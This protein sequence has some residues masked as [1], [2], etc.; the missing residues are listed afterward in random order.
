MR[1]IVLF[2]IVLSS[3]VVFA[4]HNRRD[5][6][7]IG[8]SGGATYTTLLGSNFNVKPETGWIAGLSVRGNYYNDWSAVFGMQFTESNFTIETVN[9]LA[10]RKD[11]NYKMT[12]A[13]IRFLLSYNII[14]NHLSFDLGPVLQI[15]D[16]LKID[17]KEENNLVLVG[18]TPTA[19]IAKD[20]TNISKING[21][22]Y[23]GISAGTKRVRAIIFYQYGVNNL[24]NKLNQDDI[25]V[26]KNVNKDFK[27]HIGMLSGQLL[28]NL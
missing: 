5:G 3:T 14:K 18:D 7:R 13:Q 27:A 20:L 25:L 8:I 9:A 26:F 15:S 17:S 23:A 24:W 6:N 28:I 12:G 11:V 22:A 19:L 2:F 1:R 21:N 4:Q 10:E 16:K